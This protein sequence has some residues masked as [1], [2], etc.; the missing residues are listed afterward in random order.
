[1][2]VNGIQS[3]VRKIFCNPHT[4]KCTDIRDFKNSNNNNNRYTINTIIILLSKRGAIVCA[5]SGACTCI[6]HKN[7]QIVGGNVSDNA[8]SK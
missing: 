8:L 2:I 4:W 5:T 3:I 6:H 1:M 7:A